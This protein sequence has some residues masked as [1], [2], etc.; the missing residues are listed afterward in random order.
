MGIAFI[1][2]DFSWDPSDRVWVPNGPAFYRCAIPCVAVEGV[3]GRPRFRIGEGFGVDDASPEGRFGFDTVAVKYLTSKQEYRQVAAAVDYGQRVIVDVDDLFQEVHADHVASTFSSPEVSPDRNRE[4]HEKAALAASTI[5]VSTPYLRDYWAAKHPD[6][7]MVRNSVDPRMFTRREQQEKPVV[8]WTGMLGWRSAD[9]EQMSGWMPPFMEQH[10]LTFHHSGHIPAMPGLGWA[11]ERIGL[12]REACSVHPIVP[13]TR[14]GKLMC[15]DIGVVPL[16]DIPF[17]R[18]KSFLK[19]L[20]YAAAGIP[21][22]ASDLPE[23]RLLAS[24]GIGTVASSDEEWTEALTR[25]L[26]RKA[27]VEAANAALEA[28]SAHTIQARAVEWRSALQ[29]R[30]AA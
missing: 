29:N 27:R 30:S 22:V 7:R 28:L 11:H 12:P 23:Y 1:T 4:W 6:V 16:N 24:E 5:T 3:M 2:D 17:N 18:A 15:F 25:L 26:P 8:G 19:G 21:F 20:E 9:L 10:G 14:L 13:I